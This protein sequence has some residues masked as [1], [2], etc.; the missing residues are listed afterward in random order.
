MPT[1]TSNA[2][3]LGQTSKIGRPGNAT[4][5]A[6]SPHNGEGCLNAC[7][8][9]C[10]KK[11]SP[12]TEFKERRKPHPTF[13]YTDDEVITIPIVGDGCT[14]IKVRCANPPMHR[15]EQVKRGLVELYDSDY[16]HMMALHL[17]D[18]VITGDDSEWLFDRSDKEPE[19][20]ITSDE[21]HPQVDP[22]DDPSQ[23][24][25]VSPTLKKSKCWLADTGASNHMASY[26]SLD[27]E[28][29]SPRSR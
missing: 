18:Q 24:G 27:P 3:C 16:A 9:S 11:A 29:I 22:S 25:V 12:G 1:T 6:S 28:I 4:E 10:L 13:P 21:S 19:D 5:E 14:Y 15:A 2:A 8:R 17:E 20:I 26:D 23:W 7:L